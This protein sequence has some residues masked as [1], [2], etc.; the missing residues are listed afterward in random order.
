MCTSVLIWGNIHVDGK[1]RL[2]RFLGGAHTEEICFQ[3]WVSCN[4]KL[5]FHETNVLI[6][7]IKKSKCLNRV[8]R[9]KLWPLEFLV[10]VCTVIVLFPRCVISM[11]ITHAYRKG[12][13]IRSTSKMCFFTW[14]DAYQSAVISRF[15]IIL[16]YQ[17]ESTDSYIPKPI[18]VWIY[19]SSVTYP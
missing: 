5:Q 19:T 17:C 4:V 1:I 2:N 11:K 6:P 16:V 3:Q 15:P 12:G 10:L 14:Q 13:S 9:K 7:N 18:L 8:S